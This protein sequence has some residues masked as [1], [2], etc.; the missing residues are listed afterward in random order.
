VA[1]PVVVMLSPPQLAKL[2]RQVSGL[3]YGPE[4]VLEPGAFEACIDCIEGNVVDEL[5]SVIETTSRHI[6]ILEVMATNCARAGTE[7]AES[8]TTGLG[9]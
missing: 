2:E 5:G 8:E 9:E 4:C 6:G 1:D 3:E 7:G